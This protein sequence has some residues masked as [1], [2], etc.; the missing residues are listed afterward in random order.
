MKELESSQINQVIER[1]NHG[2]FN[3]FSIILNHY[4]HLAFTI[5]FRICKNREEAED[6]TQEA[7]L[8]V[9]RNINSFSQRSKF[10]SWLYRIIYTTTITKINKRKVDLTNN[11]VNHQSHDHASI[12]NNNSWDDMIKSDNL[13]LIEKAIDQLRPTEGLVLTLY[14]LGEKS[15]EEISSITRYTKSNVKVQ[16][17]RGRKSLEIELRKVLGKEVNDLI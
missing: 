8:K 1:I 10:S 16:L 3:A 11:E 6:I 4:Q 15:I 14:Y 2:D 9:F 12:V 17:H 7:F 13:A 5:A